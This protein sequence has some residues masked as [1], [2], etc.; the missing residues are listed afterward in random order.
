MKLYTFEIDYLYKGNQYKK[1]YTKFCKYPKKTSL[2]R[3]L[4]YLMN[5][6]KIIKINI[7]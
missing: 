3:N 7:Y 1:T 6:N 4:M 5:N 2:Y